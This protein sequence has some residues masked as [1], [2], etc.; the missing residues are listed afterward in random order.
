MPALRT[1]SCRYSTKVMVMGVVAN[2]VPEHKFDGKIYIK[3]VS[4]Q[5]QAV[6]KSHLEQFHDDNVVNAEI[7]Y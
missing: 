5:I 2:P 1:V 3:R 7:K 6:Q 4:E